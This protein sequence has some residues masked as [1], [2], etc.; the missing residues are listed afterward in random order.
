MKFSIYL[1]VLLLSGN[2]FAK[3]RI[4]LSKSE[5]YISIGGDDS[6]SVPN[7]E[8]M[9]EFQAKENNLYWVASSSLRAKYFKAL[10]ISESDNLY[11]KKI[12][13]DKTEIYSISKL[14]F[15]FDMNPAGDTHVGSYG[16]AIKLEGDAIA[17]IGNSNPFK[18]VAFNGIPSLKG[19]YQLGGKLSLDLRKDGKAF[20]M[21]DSSKD[22]LS[23]K[24]EFI[25]QKGTKRD[26]V[27]SQDLMPEASVG[28]INVYAGEVL[29]DGSMLILF[30][31][32]DCGDFVKFTDAKIEKWPSLCG[33]WG[34]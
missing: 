1:F 15:V 25:L 24:F 8:A 22:S 20:D 19:I 18:D 32:H 31:Q 34:C 13:V 12:G 10:G 11:L 5:A 30:K 29:K 9:K 23:G 28:W 4:Y 16:F 17:A 3:E 7:E 33:S 21:L 27:F 14:D 2:V 26:V 6:V